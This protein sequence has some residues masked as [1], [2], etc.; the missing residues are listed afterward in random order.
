MKPP[1]HNKWV[2]PAQV[3]SS[4]A[5]DESLQSVLTPIPLDAEI[6]TNAEG[7]MEFDYSVALVGVRIARFTS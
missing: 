3:H 4:Q 6:A 7:T 2:V 1:I 5:L